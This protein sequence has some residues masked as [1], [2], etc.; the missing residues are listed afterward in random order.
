MLRFVRLFYDA[1][2]RFVADDGWAIASHIALSILMSLFPFLIFLTALAGFIGRDNLADE[3]TT[4]LLQTWPQQVADPMAQQIRAVIDNSHRGVLTFGV[5]FAVYFS[6]NGVEAL[7]VALNRSYG[8]VEQRP[9]WLTRLESIVYVL[10]SG[11]VL[12][13]IS[14]LIVLG[15]ILWDMIVK[16]VPALEPY[17]QIVTFTRIG[18]ATLI[19]VI[20]LTVLHLYLP[21][22]KRHI[23]QVWPGVIVTVVLS[24]GAGT[25]FGFYL[26]RAASNYV[27]TYAGLASVMIA[28][29]FLYTIS[30]TFIYGGSVNALLLGRSVGSPPPD[31]GGPKMDEDR[32]AQELKPAH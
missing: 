26:T 11:I 5:V 8:L 24:L 32:A 28:L 2:W 12:L 14:F 29:V 16:H 7:R 23:R 1:Y 25:A 10:V 4:L 27:A 9:W 15:P 13:A 19:T 18:V 3:A 21:C 17:W 31:M 30:A 20:A 22:G 6:S